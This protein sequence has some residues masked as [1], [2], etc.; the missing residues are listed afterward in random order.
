MRGSLGAAL[1]GKTG[2]LVEHE[3]SGVAMD[4]HFARKGDLVLAERRTLA[5]RLRIG[6]HRLGR[7]QAQRLPGSDAVTGADA[8]AVEA[9]LP[10]TC[11]FRNGGEAGVGQ[12]PLAPAIDAD[13]VVFGA[14]GELADG[15]AHARPRVSPSPAARAAIEPITD[16]AT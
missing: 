10:R 6:A 8:R 1:R 2:R 12:V 3:C 11:P 15:V 5:L 14:D 4:H 9:Q 16:A 7:R 13:A